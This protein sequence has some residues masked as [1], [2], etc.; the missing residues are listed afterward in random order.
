ML[1]HGC[2]PSALKTL[3]DTEGIPTQDQDEPWRK[4]SDKKAEDEKFLYFFPYIVRGAADERN[5][6]KKAVNWAIRQI[7]K[8]NQNL[9]E[10]AIALSEKILAQDSASAHWIA[11]DALKELRSE[12][13]QNRLKS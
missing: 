13:V 2:G 4:R 11:R 5:F 6:V 3:P 8:R 12:A 9:N 10:K 1:L 7:G